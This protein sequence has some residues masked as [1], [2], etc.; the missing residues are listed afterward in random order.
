MT[1]KA[2]LG[3]GCFWCTEAVYL[4]ISGVISVVSGYAG[5]EKPNPSYK[6]ICTGTTGHAEVI[7]IEYDP[8]ILSYSKILEIFWVAHDPTTLNRQ[9]N[10]VGTQYRSVIFYLDEK[11]K[12][13]AV[14]SKRKHAY[15]FPNPIVTE[16]MPAPTFYPA[17]DY[18]QNY[19][20]L[21]PQNPYCHY[22]IFPKL[23]KLGLKLN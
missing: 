9:G 18:H 11:Q 2:I 14:E 4:R 16:I 7:Q 23:K 15:L 19:F 8:E 17:E 12:E 10:D 20:N 13:L 6:E 21:N 1:E 22:V 5:G 3:G